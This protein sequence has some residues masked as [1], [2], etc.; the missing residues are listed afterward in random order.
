MHHPEIAEK[1]TKE[2]GSKIAPKKKKKKS[3]ADYRILL[4][5]IANIEEALAKKIKDNHPDWTFDEIVDEIDRLG[6]EFAEK[7]NKLSKRDK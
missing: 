5:K 6:K 3:H 2:H 7:E 4:Y 1:W